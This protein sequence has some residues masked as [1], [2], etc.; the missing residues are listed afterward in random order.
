M[1]VI[2]ALVGIPYSD[3]IPSEIYWKIS[4]HP[5]YMLSTYVGLDGSS[6]PRNT[7]RFGLNRNWL[8][9]IQY[10]QFLLEGSVAKYPGGNIFWE[11]VREVS[12]VN[13]ESLSACVKR[14]AMNMFGVFHVK[15]GFWSLIATYLDTPSSVSSNCTSSCPEGCNHMSFCSITSPCSTGRHGCGLW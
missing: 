15:G 3:T 2:H 8:R 12:N 1:F 4:W 5:G 10:G 7:I 9:S 14:P 6:D 13:C 11:S